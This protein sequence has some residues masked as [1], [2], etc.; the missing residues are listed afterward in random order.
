[1][2]T[3]PNI[4]DIPDGL[5]YGLEGVLADLKECVELMLSR[6]SE[7]VPVES[8]EPVNKRY[9]ELPI[10]IESSGAKIYAGIGTPEGYVAANKGSVYLRNDGGANTSIYIKESGADEAGWAAK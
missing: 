5:D 6:Y 9:I 10:E 3:F 4:R 1:M 8:Y 2:A 7:Y